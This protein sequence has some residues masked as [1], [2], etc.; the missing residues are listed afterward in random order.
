MYRTLHLSIAWS[1]FFSSVH[2]TFNKIDYMI[3]YILHYKNNLNEF[4]IIEIIQSIFCSHNG[5][6]LEV[7]KRKVTRNSLS[8]WK[9]SNTLLNNP[10][11]KK[12]SQGKLENILNQ[13]KMQMQHIKQWLRQCIYYGVY[14]NAE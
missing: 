5:I 2:G 11:V 6:K 14:C 13:V 9:L 8:S 12:R 4:K 1:R 10:T 3:D 7:I